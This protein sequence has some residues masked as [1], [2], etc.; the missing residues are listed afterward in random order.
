MSRTTRNKIRRE[1][2]VHPAPD[3][4]FYHI[5]RVNLPNP[6]LL[7]PDSDKKPFYIPL[8]GQPA[9]YRWTGDGVRVL[10]ARP[11]SGYRNPLERAGEEA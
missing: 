7:S 8:E 2:K 9:R 4:R 1:I 10:S 3:P 6:G 11:E 5:Y